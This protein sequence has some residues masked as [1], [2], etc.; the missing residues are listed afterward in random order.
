[1]T[2]SPLSIRTNLPP[3]PGDTVVYTVPEGQSLTIKSIS[4]EAVFE[5]SSIASI[6]AIPSGESLEDRWLVGYKIRALR[7]KTLSIPMSTVLD[8]GS[9]LV[10]R[11][12]SVALTVHITGFLES[13]EALASK[14]LVSYVYDNSASF[15]TIYTATAPCV[16]TEMSFTSTTDPSDVVIARILQVPVGESVTYKNQIFVGP[17][18]G[19]HITRAVHVFELGVG[20]MISASL[21][22]G[23]FGAA[24]VRISG[25]V[26]AS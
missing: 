12:Y 16:I 19:Q 11:T 24:V 18:L 2:T 7:Q 1:M 13:G 10:I 22:R 9:T 21:R 3:T 8:S 20:D 4:M 14:H 5:T 26:L 23:D 15:D 6:Y 25:K 17:V